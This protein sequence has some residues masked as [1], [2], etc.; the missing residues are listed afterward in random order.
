MTEQIRARAYEL[1][2]L[3]G[4]GDGCDLDD[5]LLAEAQVMEKAQ[6]KQP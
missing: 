1:Y 4:Q 6:A 5:W 3:R 2:E